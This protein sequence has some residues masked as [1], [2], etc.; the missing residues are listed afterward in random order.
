MILSITMTS[1]GRPVTL[2]CDVYAWGESPQTRD[3]PG[4][5]AG[6]EL[7]ACYLDGQKLDPSRFS[8]D[9]TDE[10]DQLIEAKLMERTT[11]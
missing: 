8:D 5:P 11:T 1:L 9:E 7:V 2:S 6:W 10:L 4:E 3:D